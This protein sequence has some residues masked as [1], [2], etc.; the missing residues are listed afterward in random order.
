MRQGGACQR[1]VE[2]Y[3]FRDGQMV[4]VQ[5]TPL[6]ADATGLEQLFNMA[7]DAPLSYGLAYVFMAMLLGWIS[8]VLFRGPD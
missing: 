1:N 2:V 7:H 3:L 4:C 5:S 6:F 8:S